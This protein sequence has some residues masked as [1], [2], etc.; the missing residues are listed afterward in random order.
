MSHIPVLLREILE[1]ADASLLGEKKQFLDVTAGGGGHFCEILNRFPHSTGIC[2]DQDPLAKERIFKKLNDENLSARGSFVQKNFFEAPPSEQNFD[3]ILADLGVSS[4][5]LDDNR[6]GMSLYA[7]VP[8]D[9]RMNPDSGL[10]LYDWIQEMNE[11]E[12]ANIFYEFGDEP[13]SRKLAKKMKAWDETF[14]K[15]SKYFGEQIANALAYGTR[16]RVHPAT[17]IFQ[18]LRIAINE[19]LTALESLMKWGPKHLKTG[20]RLAIISFHSGEDRIVKHGFRNLEKSGYSVV[21]KRPVIASEEEV[22][23]NPRS[24]SAKLRVL[25]RSST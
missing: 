8:P 21:F 14:F 3:F 15:S 11:E 17:R 20:G 19:E 16:S 10:P 13:R 5:Q 12:L 24:R 2:W 9:F 22:R 23:D 18:A 25:E 4:F 6:R 1:A 7:E